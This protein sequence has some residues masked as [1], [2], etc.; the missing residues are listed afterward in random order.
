MLWRL[1]VPTLIAVLLLRCAGPQGAALPAPTSPPSAATSAA[2]TS[3]PDRTITVSGIPF[4]LEKTATADVYLDLRVWDVTESVQDVQRGTTAVEANF[5]RRFARRPEVFVFGSRDTYEKGVQAVF[6]RSAG[7]SAGMTVGDRVV[8]EGSVVAMHELTHVMLHQI[9]PKGLPV[10]LDEGTAYLDHWETLTPYVLWQAR[11]RVASLAAIGALPPLE[12]CSPN[13]CGIGMQML[14]A[15]M[16]RDGF[17]R[18]IDLIGEGESLEAAYSRVTGMA[19]SSF[20]RSFSANAR[21]LADR[22][23]GL[24]LLPDTD[25]SYRPVARWLAFGFAPGTRI[26]IRVKDADESVNPPRTYTIAADGSMD[27]IVRGS[28]TMTVSATWSGG[29]VA[30]TVEVP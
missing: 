21:G 25:R 18:M 13:V 29:S 5:K 26:V 27:D 23:P 15:P 16:G 8:V 28:G 30:A 10:W 7:T 17:V 19:L 3:T 11:H 22:Y 14:R 24:T 6:G 9:V 2:A 1:A 4:V 20:F 12:V